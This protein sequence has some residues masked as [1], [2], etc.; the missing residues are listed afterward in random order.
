MVFIGI[1][2]VI[3]PWLVEKVV[4]IQWDDLDPAI[5]ARNREFIEKLCAERGL[6]V[7]RI[8]VIPSGTP[9][10][11]SFGHVPGDSRVVTS[12]L[13]DVL[14]VDEANAVLAHEIGHIEHWDFAVMTLAALARL[15]LYQVYPF[16]RK[17]IS[18]RALAYGAYL[19]YWVSQ[20]VVLLLNRTREYFADHYAAEVTRAPEA[21]S[22]ALIKIAYGMVNDGQY[23]RGPEA[24]DG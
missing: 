19:F 14:T 13:L 12:G 22:S 9:N 5:P 2:Y 20:F 6:R 1:Q 3:G 4:E 23:K 8:G 16:T 15:L 11:L 7:P 24:E 18:F 10:A 17:I 21:L